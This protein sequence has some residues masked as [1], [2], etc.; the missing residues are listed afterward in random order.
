MSTLHGLLAEL[1]IEDPAMHPERE[2]PHQHKWIV[3]EK[4]LPVEGKSYELAF[5]K[6]LFAGELKHVVK[7]IRIAGPT[8]DG[9]IDL[10]A[11]K[12]LD[13]AL[14]ACEVKAFR[15]IA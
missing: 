14:Q 4:F 11:A 12:P 5:G 1:G 6:I 15:P 10:D 3:H 8:P 9:W 2:A 13:K 7:R